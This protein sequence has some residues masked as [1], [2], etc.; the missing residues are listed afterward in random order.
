VYV[1]RVLIVMIG[2]LF[3]V[4][5]CVAAEDS[6]STEVLPKTC[7]GLSDL[8]P[9]ESQRLPVPYYCQVIDDDGP[10]PQTIESADLSRIAVR[11]LD[12]L[13]SL[14]FLVPMIGA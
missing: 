14:G 12:W 13:S 11:I 7:A 3:V 1:L 4:S 5:V 9:S 10:V 6:R 8:D 2:V